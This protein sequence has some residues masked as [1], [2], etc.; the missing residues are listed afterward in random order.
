MVT[1]DQL[2]TTSSVQLS[3]RNAILLSI[4][5]KGCHPK[6]RV[7]KE[8]AGI[9]LTTIDGESKVQ[10]DGECSNLLDPSVDHVMVKNRFGG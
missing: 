6:K 3:V 10:F 2:I 4:D 7:R 8:L 9:E 1:E 5:A